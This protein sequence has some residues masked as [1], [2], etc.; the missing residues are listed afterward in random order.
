MIMVKEQKKEKKDDTAC[1]LPLISMI[2]PVYNVE[3]YLRECLESI[4]AQ[5]YSNVEV[6]VVNDGSTDGCGE[7]CDEY[8][9]RDKRFQVLHIK[10]SG[11]AEARN[12]ALDRAKGE[13]IVFLD[14][15]D[16]IESNTIERMLSVCMDYQADIV[17]CKYSS[18]GVTEKFAENPKQCPPEVFEK[19]ALFDLVATMDNVVWNKLYRASL[20]FEIRFPK[21]K[22]F[23]DIS[24]VYKLGMKANRVVK[25][26]DCLIHYRQRISGL[27]HDHSAK[28]LIAYWKANYCKYTDLSSVSSRYAQ[29]PV[30][31]SDCIYAGMR[32]WCFYSGLS[33][34][35]K[36]MLSCT[37][38]DIETFIRAHFHMIMSD[39]KIPI[40]YKLLCPCLMFQNPFVFWMMNSVVTMVKEIDNNITKEVYFP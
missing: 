35:E 12:Y 3:P 25:I 18:F 6:L 21:G 13:Y 16:W 9:M 15:D 8:A 22:I 11:L 40:K 38:S 26:S 5:T 31:I 4:N 23:E 10:N 1:L 20:F 33:R 34:E 19:D 36:K 37:L 39:K 27:S 30:L 28:N 32:V 24:T 14:S 2:V 17:V 29:H 7:I